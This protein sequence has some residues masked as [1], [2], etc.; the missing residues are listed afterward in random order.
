MIDKELGVDEGG[1]VVAGDGGA[2]TGDVDGDENTGTL[3][4]VRMKA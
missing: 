3:P 2:S 1:G 4:L